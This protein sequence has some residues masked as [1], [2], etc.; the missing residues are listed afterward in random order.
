MSVWLVG[1]FSFVLFWVVFP[2]ARHSNV[3]RKSWDRT[4]LLSSSIDK[5]TVDLVDTETVRISQENTD[6]RE[7]LVSIRNENSLDIEA[8]KIF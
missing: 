8:W 6:W 4:Y 1:C 2:I 3:L 7:F 5:A